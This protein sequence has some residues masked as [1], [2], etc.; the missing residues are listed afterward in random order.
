MDYRFKD[1]KFLKALPPEY[2]V[3]VEPN[4]PSRLEEI[5]NNGWGNGDGP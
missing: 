5:F 3:D 1:P 2:H 4:V